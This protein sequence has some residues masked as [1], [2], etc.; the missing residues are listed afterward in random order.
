MCFVA[1]P[2]CVRVTDVQYVA[3]PNDLLVN[4]GFDDGSI[5]F[6]GFGGTTGACVKVDFFL[7]IKGA[8]NR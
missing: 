8:K 3:N 7:L 6:V 1:V 4:H 2:D 5:W